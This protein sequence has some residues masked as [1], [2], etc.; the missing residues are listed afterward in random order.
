MRTLM[1]CLAI[2]PALAV[3]LCDGN[4]ITD[5]KGQKND[6]KNKERPGASC[7]DGNRLPIPDGQNRTKQENPCY[8][9][10]C[11]NGEVTRTN[12]T[13]RRVDYKGDDK[14]EGEKE[15]P[16]CCP[17]R[18]RMLGKSRETLDLELPGPSR[19]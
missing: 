17:P 4:K 12:C 14:K 18:N 7:P 2:F 19:D 3:I 13:E 6:T 11:N 15:F 5:R 8:L 9:L 1:V 16:E 10:Q